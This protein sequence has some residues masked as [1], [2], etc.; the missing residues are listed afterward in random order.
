[1]RCRRRQS[2]AV[3][4]VIVTSEALLHRKQNA[5]NGSRDQ[6]WKRRRKSQRC[7]HERR[8]RASAAMA[9]PRAAIWSTSSYTL[10][11]LTLVTSCACMLVGFAARSRACPVLLPA[12]FLQAHPRRR[13]CQHSHADTLSTSGNWSSYGG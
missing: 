1:M 3:M 9:R 6:S 4:P 11:H 5:G 8:R 10:H 2:N 7:V 13:D 12:M